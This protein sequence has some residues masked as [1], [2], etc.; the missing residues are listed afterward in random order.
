MAPVVLC[1]ALPQAIGKLHTLWCAFA[2]FYDR[3]GD[4]ANARI[5]FGKATE[6]R[7]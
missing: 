6:A 5:I 2:K 4:L 1:P 7:V 3:H